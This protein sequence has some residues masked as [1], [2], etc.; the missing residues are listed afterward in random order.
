MGHNLTVE[1]YPYSSQDSE[2]MTCAETT[3]WSI[4]EY[5][6]TRYSEYRTILPSQLISELER[7]SQ[8][9]ILPS[10]G[11][12]YC[13][14]SELLK[15]FGF[16]PRLYARSALKKRRSSHKENFKKYFIIM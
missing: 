16:S 13:K 4:L 1:A 15:I 9:R 11:L 8:E 10:R 2:T 3:V 14:V 6:G 5:F 7:I 12:D